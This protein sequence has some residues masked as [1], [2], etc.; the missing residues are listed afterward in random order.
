MTRAGGVMTVSTTTSRPRN[1]PV[2]L[3]S[4]VGRER[5]VAAVKRL[6][7]ASRLLTLT[8]PGGVGKTRLALRTAGEIHRS[9][10]DGVWFVEL[11]GV[12]D[13]D[14]VPPAVAATMGIQGPAENQPL[15]SIVDFLRGRHVLLVLDNCEHLIDACARL[16]DALLRSCPELHILATSRQPMHVSGEHILA[17]PPLPAPPADAK[18]SPSSLLQQHAALRLFVDRAGSVQP[19][20]AI[21]E[22]NQLAVSEICRRLDG[23]PL[24]IELAAR[25]L[26]ALSVNQLHARLDDRYELLT[27]GNPAALP[28]QQTLRALI[29]WSFDLCSAAQQ[30]LW[31]R[32]SVFG[33]GFDLDAAETV[34]SDDAL[35]ADEVFEVLAGLVDKSIVTAKPQGEQMRYHQAETLRE[36]GRERL[37]DAAE[38]ALRR[39]HRDWC[40][41]LVNQAAAGWF[42]ADQVGLFTRLR[43]EHVNLRAALGFCLSEPGE[44]GV[45]LEMASQLRFYWL[46]SGTMREGRHWLD[47]FL[48]RYD[49]RDLVLVEALRVNG[50]LATLLNANDAAQ[51]LLE[52]ARGVAEELADPSAIAGVTQSLGLAALFRGDADLGAAQL[53]EALQQHQALGDLAATAYGQVQLALAKV[54]LGDHD[55]ALE[56]IEDSLQICEPSGEH[57]TTSL[58]LFA[59]AVEA[60]RRGDQE[61]STQAALKSI[62]LR[63]PLQDRRNIGLNFEA[64]AWA[65]A[66]SGD[67]VRAARLFGAAQAVQQSIGT[68]LTALGHLAALHAVYEPVARE[69]L[70]EEAFESELEAGLRMDFDEA[71]DYALGEE[72]APAEPQAEASEDPAATAGLTRREREVAELVGQGMSNKEIAAALVVSKR[73]AESHVE[74]IL[75]KLGFTSRAQISAWLAEHRTSTSD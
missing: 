72:S 32:L 44:V 45:G 5:E 38:S 49:A 24:A 36:F 57:W 60:C 25:R 40:R 74:H 48:A 66:A 15:D 20:F 64:L 39:R 30:L 58:A 8:G 41:G 16:A 17:V 6:L 9:F 21:D 37:S 75:M 23:I 7:A 46:M 54:L 2:D 22:S 63:R 31:A 33:E 61:R 19:E 70:G 28:R 47:S 68:S 43:R 52:K 13:A 56:L 42:T 27:G 1:L 10:R 53:G 4:F 29:E 62:R 18:G 71:V 67:G 69:A 51:L 50:H 26:R 59:L 12:P 11:A 35:P 55:G 65:A 3:T 73:T 34:C 14:L